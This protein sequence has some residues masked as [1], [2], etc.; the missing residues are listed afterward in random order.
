MIFFLNLII[1][2][3]YSERIGRLAAKYNYTPLATAFCFLP[4]FCLWTVICGGQYY[5]GTDYPSY[6][7][8]FNGV[9][10]DQFYRSGEI[11]FAWVVEN[12]ISIGI[13][14]N[15][16]YAF[17]YA[18]CFLF[19]CF[20]IYEA[21]LEK[22]YI[23]IFLFLL[24]A[25]TG[26]FN[27]QLNILRQ[28]IATYIGSCGAMMIIKGRK[29][30]GLFLILAAT[31]IHLSA[32]ILLLFFF[33]KYISHL[34]EKILYLFVIIGVGGTFAITVNSLDFLYPVLPKGYA[35]YIDGGGIQ[36]RGIIPI[37]TKFIYLPIIIIS[38]RKR[39]FF[40]LSPL[41][42]TLF[43][44]GIIGFSFKLM[45]INIT[46]VSRLSDYWLLFNI[47]PIYFL[48]SWLYKSSSIKKRISGLF[49]IFAISA[50]YFIKTCV[51]ASAEYNY[52]SVYQFFF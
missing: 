21:K 33:S 50:L 12:L 36:Y 51:F 40:C 52:A 3:V 1:T 49:L 46:I 47:F 30:N 29:I 42:N 28:A 9:D 15:W 24:I 14:G 45:L 17:F 8:F 25:Y 6:I 39:R 5:V 35:W 13:T 38:I 43:I 16:V 37:I 31:T 34:S 22:Q 18:V 44:W 4:L 19:L 23:F 48:I 20:F 10:Y 2:I 11:G 26:M 32:L 27:N 7:R 41:H